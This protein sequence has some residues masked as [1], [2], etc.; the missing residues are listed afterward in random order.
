MSTITVRHVS[1]ELRDALK[2]KAKQ[3]GRSVQ[4]VALEALHEK[5]DRKSAEEW[6]RETRE[7]ARKYGTKLGPDEILRAVHE[8]RGDSHP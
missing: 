1:P 8:E 6:L 2:E 7:I 3:S 5:V 4:Q